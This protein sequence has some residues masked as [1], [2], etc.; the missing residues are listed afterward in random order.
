MGIALR[1]R[2]WLASPLAALCALGA[3]RARAAPQPVAAVDD[4]APVDEVA[5]G[6][7]MSPGR[8]GEIEPA[9]R[10]RIGNAGFIVGPQG[11]VAIDSGVSWRQGQAL[12]AAIARTTSAP[13]R[14]LVLTHT[15]QEFLFGAAAFQDAGVPVAMHRAA[16]RLMAARCDHCLK[17]LRETLGEAEMRNS[18]VVKPDHLL[19]GTAPI[20]LAALADIGRP[21]RLQAFG[22]QAHSSGPGD[23]AVFDDATRTVLAGGLLDAHTIPDVQDADFTGWREALAALD[24]LAPAHIVPG[25]GPASGAA[26]IGQIGRYLDQLEARA[27]ALLKAGTPLSDVP[28]ASQ[29]PD[30]ADWDQAGTIH[31][32]NAAI[33]FLRL[34]R[35]L[36][37]RQP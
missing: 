27:A 2:R 35:A 20:A 31:R 33:V 13:L 32:R 11:V 25:H 29:L 24:R 3:G 22:P 34:E 5:P 1:R 14:L 17:L 37:L 16:A 19:D 9:H 6:V 18:R 7:F 21:V 30:F 8:P 4:V 36:L 23:M 15:R 12:R 28:D 26:L 10:G